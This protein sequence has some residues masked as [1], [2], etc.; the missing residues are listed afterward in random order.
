MFHRALFM[1]YS[2]AIMV[3]AQNVIL[4]SSQAA[5]ALTSPKKQFGFNPGDDYQLANYQQLTT[6]WQRL[7]AESSRMKLIPIGP[8]EE[9]RTQWMAV[10]SSVSNLRRLETHR[11]TARRLA[12]AEGLTD[13]EARTL[14][15]KGRAIVLVSGGLHATETLG[16]QQLLE[17]VYRLISQNDAETLRILENVIVLFVPAN[18]DGMDLVVNWYMRE[19]TP[20]KRSLSTVPRLYQKYTGHDNNRDFYAVTQLETKNLCRVMFRE[21]FPQ[22][23]YDHHQSGPP[24]TVM[25]APPFR[26]PFN[27]HL[28]PRVMNG[29]EAVGAAMVGRFLAEGKP[30]VTVRSGAR[31]SA[32]YNGGLRAIGYYHNAICL[33][34]ETIGSP[35]PSSVPYTP[36]TLLPRNDLLAPIAPQPWHMKQSI[37]YAVTAN[38]AVFDYAARNRAELLWSRYAIGR[39]AIAAG[40][41]D[42]WTPSPSRITQAQDALKTTTNTISPGSITA[43]AS[44]QATAK[45][46][47][48][49]T[50]PAVATNDFA[51]Y[52]QA[53]ADRNPRG[54]ILPADQPDFGTATKFINTLIE[55]GVR[56]WRATNAFAAAGHS[57]PEGSYAVPCNQAFRAHVLDSF[58][59]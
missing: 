48:T 20:E 11:T 51:K 56:V 35:N 12:L 54:Y 29:V 10:I 24:G 34:T 36:S 42:T 53:P 49:T 8:T 43:S 17:T 46:K 27:Y 25:F 22:I 32:W 57:Y 41:R 4:P 14:A 31:Y 1:G 15:N 2:L 37:E 45:K 3:M 58:E 39:D 28:D 30:G 7:A 21:W 13:A 40:H 55:N 47:K 18:P 33:L 5:I 23:I 50:S 19:P 52:F 38:L 16:S 9:G 44:A 6:Y 59:P 26:D